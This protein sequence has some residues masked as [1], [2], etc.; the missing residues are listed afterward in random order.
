[1]QSVSIATTLEVITIAWFS[2]IKVNLLRLGFKAFVSTN[3]CVSRIT[4]YLVSDHD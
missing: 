2:L 3:I 4:A 1:M